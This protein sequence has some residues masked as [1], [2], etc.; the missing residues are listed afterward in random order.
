VTDHNSQFV[1]VPEPTTGLLAFGGAAAAAVARLRRLRR[2][3]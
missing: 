3:G 1:V 2:N